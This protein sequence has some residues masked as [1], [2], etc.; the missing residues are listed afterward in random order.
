MMDSRNQTT[1]RT[2]AT[3]LVLELAHDTRAWHVH[4]PLESST[5]GTKPRTSNAPSNPGARRNNLWTYLPGISFHHARTRRMDLHQRRR[6]NPRDGRGR[7]RP[8]PIQPRKPTTNNRITLVVCSS[9]ARILSS[10]CRRDRS[11][12]HLDLTNLGHLAHRPGTKAWML[13]QLPGQNIR[14][15]I[16]P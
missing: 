16:S 7:A 11:K 13:H 2:Q 3:R 8:L 6:N 15:R 12:C 9:P 10:F 5:H 14:P 4:G 1:D